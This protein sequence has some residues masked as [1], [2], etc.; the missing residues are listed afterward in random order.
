MASYKN[1]HKRA[2]PKGQQYT[3][4]FISFKWLIA[5][6]LVISAAGAVIGLSF[7]KK[8]GSNPS[9]ENIPTFTVRRDDLIIIVSEGGS[10]RAQ[11]IIE[12]KNEV[13]EREMTIMEIVP[14]GTFIT[15]ED[16]NNG[17]ILVQLDSSALKDELTEREMHFASAEAS[18]AEAKESY[19]IQANQNE[20]DITA[21]KLNVKFT[22]DFDKHRSRL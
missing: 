8:T 7:L 16:V 6:I 18:Y 13:D 9:D 3:A 10:I 19:D 21:G 12:V 14:E 17:K 5:L 22:L 20:S 1:K 15:Q 4:E 2:N 11:N